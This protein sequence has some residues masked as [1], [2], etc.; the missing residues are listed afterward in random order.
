[1]KTANLVAILVTALV[2]S[3][4]DGGGMSLQPKLPDPPEAPVVAVDAGLKQ[5]IFS[6]AEVPGTTHY[7]LMENPDGHSGFTQTGA[8]ISAGS[9]SVTQPIAVHRQDWPNALYMV[10]ACNG[11]GCTDSS[12][13]SATDLQPSAVGFFKASNND[14]G[15]VGSWDA[16]YG[17]GDGFGA[18]VALSAD[19]RTLVVGAP[20]EDGG[21]S[22]IN[23]EQS[24][25]AAFEAGAVYV[26]R[27]A[28]EKW[29]QQAYVKAS[30]AEGAD[31]IDL[32]YG[33]VF[34][35][36]V[37]LSADGLTLAVGAPREDGG[38]S[39][40]DGDQSDN[41]AIQAGAVYIFRLVNDEWSQQAYIK[42]SNT[43]GGEW[44]DRSLFQNG[45]YFGYLVSL[46]GDGDTLAV[47]APGEDSGATGIDGDQADNSAPNS[48]AVYIF[49]YDGS[50]W[51][52]QAYVKPSSRD[53]GRIGK[54]ALSGDGDTLTV[55]AY[56]FRFDGMEWSEQSCIL[57]LPDGVCS[58]VG[59][60]ISADG[61]TIAIPQPTTIPIYRYDGTQWSQQ[62][63][64]TF[65][66]TD[67]EHFF[68]GV[69]LSDDGDILAAHAY[70]WENG[71][72]DYPWWT[73]DAIYVFRF[74]D[75][76][77]T[78]ESY[79]RNPRPE[80]SSNPACDYQSHEEYG[81]AI[82]ISGDANTL[83]VGAPGENSN[84]TGI[85]GDQ[86]DDSVCGSGAVYL[87]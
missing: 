22:G 59:S 61:N 77:W 17:V 87:Y 73:T 40:V 86:N 37:S 34:G 32:A 81:R 74:I 44:A 30:N 82:S 65:S 27:V 69:A 51:S 66:S 26:F 18:A 29:S 79:V 25:D 21:S 41:S 76:V 2:F 14:G 9:V 13:V 78:Q 3:A 39:G 71:V 7:R 33:D 84:A 49:R 8:D 85:G 1:M 11:G 63:N 23:G 38:S 12:E 67:A 70:W 10:R 83:A 48:G 20:G 16:E 68:A 15:P 54:P 31:L 19:G 55:G 6:W 28:G 5:L 60:V 42:A 47:T 46:S 35:T 56:V 62:D 75:E 57:T 45:D 72:P 43:E 50:D 64:V 53:V 58:G 80:R 52:Q 24:N 4:C 36:S